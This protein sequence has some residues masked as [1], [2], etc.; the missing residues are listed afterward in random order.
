MII[1]IIAAAI[2]LVP[3]ISPT[4][5][6]II[7]FNPLQ[8]LGRAIATWLG[9]SFLKFRVKVGMSRISAVSG[10]GLESRFSYTELSCV[11]L[12]PQHWLARQRADELLGEERTQPT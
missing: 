12:T 3:P 11:P 1:I 9:L 8:T 7:W 5:A 2:Y 10:T 6:D 4:F